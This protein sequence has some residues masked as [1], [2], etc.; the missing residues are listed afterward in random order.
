MKRVM[1]SA[2][3]IAAMCTTAAAQDTIKP[4]IPFEGMDLSWVNGQ[5]RQT[6]FPLTL[7]DKNGETILT[8]VA[9]M[10]AY[11]NYDFNRPID[12]THT[13]SSSIGRSNEFTINMASVGLETNYKNIIGRLWLQY[14]QMGSIVQDL[15]GSVGH[16]RNTNINNLNYIREAAAGYHFNK[17]YGINVEMGIFMSYIGLESFVLGENWSYQRSAVCEFTPFYFT[18]ARVQMFPSK[19]LRTEVWL[20]NGWQSYNSWNQR[21]GFGSSTYYRPNENLQLVANF[22]LA[23]KDTRNST[24]S[25][26][27]HDNSIVYRYFKNRTGGG[28]ISQAALSLNNHYGFQDGDGA[29][30]KD[31]YMAGT[32]LAN[33]FWFAKNKLALTLRGDIMTN[34][35]AYLAYSPSPVAPNDY[36]DAMEADPKQKLNI[37]QF[38]ATFD[39][40]PNDHVT[41]RMEYGYRGANVPYFAGRG[42]TTSPDGWVDTPTNN[43]RPDL[44]K[45]E[46]RLTVAA[47]FRL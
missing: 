22:Y 14:G 26:F 28:F 18:G 36:T 38:C 41:F 39:V 45:M 34:P 6:D 10:D 32:S 17:W 37:G 16:G 3:I 4:K 15:D 44:R 42:G 1:I 20:L 7:K 27:H 29:K 33:R 12:N 47:S 19:K 40:M 21:I 9:Y 25:R 8:G 23:G 35:T 24:R 46:N 30:P 5:N 11:Y 43:W 13:I 31:Q 2:A